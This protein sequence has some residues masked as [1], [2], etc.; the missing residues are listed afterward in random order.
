MARARMSDT[1]MV[2]LPRALR[3]AVG[4]FLG[5]EVEITESA[6]RLIVEP[7]PAVS[8]ETMD[9]RKMAMEALLAKRIRY[10][11]PP[12]TD[13]MIDQAILDEAKRRWDRVQRQWDKDVDENAV[14]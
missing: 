13:E 6:G 11:G 9:K 3:D 4:L 5:S 10:E 7:V 2:E 14:D 12:I 8:P 1:G